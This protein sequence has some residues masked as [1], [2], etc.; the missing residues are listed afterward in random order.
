MRDTKYKSG[1][2]LIEVLIAVL[3]VG[4]A[5]ASLMAANGA[6]TKANGAGTDLSTAEF[7]I[8]QIRELA[9]LLPVIDPETELS[10]FG[11]ESGETLADYDDLDDFN[12]ATFSP[13]ISAERTP[14]NELAAFSQKITVENVN[15]SDF[16]QVV[17]NHSS[18]FVRVTV[19]VYLNSNQ[20]SSAN[21]LRAR[22]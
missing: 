13:P 21:W 22:Y 20:I 6:F 11:P 1:F 15:A 14:L 8:G 2:S 5:I 4:V 16:E 7:I 9:M 19:I 10:T 17:A 18:S 12:G 3:L